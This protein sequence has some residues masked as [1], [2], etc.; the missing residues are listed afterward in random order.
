MS[1]ARIRLPSRQN[2]GLCAVDTQTVPRISR[3]RHGHALPQISQ[4]PCRRLSTI[5][6][7]MQGADDLPII[8][9]PF[10]D[11]LAE[12]V[13]LKHTVAGVAQRQCRLDRT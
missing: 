3:R 2:H 12:G 13:A 4:F 9:K 1:N 6:R 5:G 7:T 10:V 11:R 8:V